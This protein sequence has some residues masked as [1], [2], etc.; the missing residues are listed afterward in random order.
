MGNVAFVLDGSGDA[1]HCPSM[2]TDDR[3]FAAID[4]VDGFWLR[5]W[6]P[7]GDFDGVRHMVLPDVVLACGG[8]VVEGFDAL[9]AWIEACKRPLGDV[10]LEP[11]ETF[12]S[13][14]A[15]RVTSLWRARGF[16]RGLFGSK[17]TG[18][19]VELTGIAVWSILWDGENPRIADGWIER[20]L[21]EAHERLR[22]PSSTAV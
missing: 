4:L 7:S 1:S 3:R 2:T 12:P 15:T 13:V 20:G 19:A 14:D 8:Q 22:A 16:D 10:R 6:N 9:V 21:W 17:P 5:V 11:V 18:A